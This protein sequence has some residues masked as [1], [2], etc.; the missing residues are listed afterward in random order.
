MAH[1]YRSCQPDDYDNSMC[2]QILGFDIM[3]D[4]HFRPWLIEVNQS[5]SFATDSALDYE[6]KK[7]V[8]QD[9]FKLLNLSQERRE[10]M[11]KEK[12]RQMEERIFT[13]KQEKLDPARK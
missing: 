3:I 1:I 12:Q 4:K 5:P 6:V 9:A 2:F 8:I 13:G 10:E 11:I 7:N